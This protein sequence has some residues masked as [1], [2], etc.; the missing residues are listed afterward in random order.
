[1]EIQKS[2]DNNKKGT[3]SNDV[4]GKNMDHVMSGVN[5]IVGKKISM[6][7]FWNTITTFDR[8]YLR[9]YLTNKNAEISWANK[10]QKISMDEHYAR[11]YGP[12]ML[13][14]QHKVQDMLEEHR[15][16]I[17]RGWK[18]FCSDLFYKLFR[19]S[20]FLDPERLCERVKG[21]FRSHFFSVRP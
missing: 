7:R 8:T 9:K 11:L 2:E 3:I 15:K 4:H 19:Y 18:Y 21:I 14:A 17:V 13:V 10:V 6:N 12:S 5:S 1:M 20:I 16:S